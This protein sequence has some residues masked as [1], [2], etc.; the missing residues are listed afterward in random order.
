[1]SHFTVLVI[2]DDPEKALAPFQENNMGDCPEEYLEFFDVEDKSRE[3]YEEGG[4]DMIRCPDGTL[5][6]PWDD[7]FRVSGSIGIGTGTHT[8]PEG[9]GFEKVHVLHKERFATFEE[10][11]D[12]WKGYKKRDPEMGRYGY[13][14]NPNAKWDWYSLGGRWTGYFKLKEGA[15]GET[16][17]PDLMTEVAENGWVDQAR[18]KDIDFGAM[19]TDAT[20]RAEERWDKM[21]AELAEAEFGG[22][23]VTPEITNRALWRI[24]AEPGMTKAEY[25]NN[26]RKDAVT[27]FA[28]L[29]DGMWYERGE[30]GWWGCVSNEKKGCNWNDE[31]MALFDEIDDDELLSVYDCHI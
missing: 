21:L 16:G 10:F 8:V 6:Y 7:R 18:K 24:G 15:V 17:I 28:V 30:M 25:V 14:E 19:V 3:E 1:M 9:A 27:T 31:F 11:I 22:T 12:E 26:A 29:K 13:W 20:D 5:A 2:G 23:Y 4:T